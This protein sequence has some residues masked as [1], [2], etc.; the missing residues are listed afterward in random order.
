[1]S[2]HY[3]MT[4]ITNSKVPSIKSNDDSSNK[5]SDD[6]ILYKEIDIK[7]KDKIEKNK[8]LDFLSKN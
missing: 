4:K 8:F 2:S 3:S 6:E 7:L 5:S 1:M